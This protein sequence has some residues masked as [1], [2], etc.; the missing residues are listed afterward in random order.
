FIPNGIDTER[1]QPDRARGRAARAAWGIDPGA[2]V[3]GLVGRLDPMKGHELF[4]RAAAQAAQKKSDLVFVCVGEG[5]GVFRESLLKLSREL[6]L[7]GRV[8][9]SSSRNDMNDVYN[10]FDVV[11]SASVFGEGFSNA[12]GEAMAC[13]VP[14]VVTD[15]GDSALIVGDTGLVVPP[16]DPEA[17]VEGLCTLIG[18]IEEKGQELSTKARERIVGRFSRHR[19]VGTT[20]RVLSAL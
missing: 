13:G 18:V 2:R 1:F 5:S 20:Y 12:V 8:V 15:V 11:C 19:L 14:C 17:L 7:D 3:V 4:L 9:W 16:G 6:A 10:A